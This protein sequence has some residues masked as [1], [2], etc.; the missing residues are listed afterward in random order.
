MQGASSTRV[1][2]DDGTVENQILHVWIIGKV[3]MHEFPDAV[4][5]PTGISFVDTV[6]VAILFWQQSPLGTTAGDPQNRFDESPALGFPS[7]VYT[8]A[9]ARELENLGPVRIF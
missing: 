3:L 8:R 4:V 7:D 6:P 5:T 9:G 2:P 1:S